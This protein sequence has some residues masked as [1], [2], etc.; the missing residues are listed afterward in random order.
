VNKAVDPTCR[1]FQ[2]AIDV[3]SRPWTGLILGLLADG[4]LRFSELEER[5]HGVG[6]K[7]LSARLKDLE[8]RRIVAR[9]V[10]PGPPVRVQYTLTGKG[11][12]FG[13]VAEAIERWGRELVVGEAPDAAPPARGTRR[14]Q[15]RRPR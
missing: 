10:D 9:H 14:S 15:A 4:P 8:T 5:A 11:R 13:E 6:A 2:L 12:A 7:T 1:A 3:L